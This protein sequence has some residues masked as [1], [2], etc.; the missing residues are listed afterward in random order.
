MGNAYILEA[1]RTAGC[2]AKRGGFANM[3]PD[4]LASAA[5]KGLMDRCG[6]DGNLV[7]DVVLGTAFP[8]GEQGNN[9]ARG[10]AMGAG[11]PI[12]AAG[13]TINRFCSSGLQAV[14]TSAY[15]IMAGH[16]DCIIAAGAESMTTIPMG[17]SKFA[18]NPR[19]AKEWPESYAN[20]GITA[21]YVADR[22]NI[23]REDMDKFAVESHRRATVAIAAGKFTEIVPVE[24]ES[25]ALKDGKMVCKKTMV[26]IDDGSRADVNF[27]GLTKLK[28]AF[29]IGGSVTAGNSSQMTDGAAAVMVV[30]EEFLKKTGLKPVARF[31]SFAVTG[32]EPEYM[33][34]GPIKAIPK[35]LE[36]AGLTLADIGVVE[37]NEAFAAQSLAVIRTL[38][39]DNMNINPNGGAIALG[40]PLGCT[41]A[42]LTAQIIKEMHR[43]GHRYGMVSMCIGGGMGAA[44]IFELVK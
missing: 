35:A 34:I 39:M 22:Y 43:E 31:V 18:G 32:C 23:S 28:G 40:H 8:E 17:G 14:A 27:A 44:G 33:G 6:V 25:Y 26:V 21:E 15:Q 16:A 7:E 41:G 13:Q 20:M 2:K 3:R 1:V 24:A 36:K 38:G 4:D 9:L 10:A 29:K 42:K 5:I 11:L 30:S 12:T 19:L 37:L